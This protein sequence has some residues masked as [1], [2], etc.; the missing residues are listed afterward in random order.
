MQQ[1]LHTRELSD[2]LKLRVQERRMALSQSKFEAE[3]ASEAKSVFLANISHE[4]R[5]AMNG[6]IGL[7][8]LLAE[9]A[10]EA[11]PEDTR[12]SGFA[13]IKVLPAAHA[14]RYPYAAVV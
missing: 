3:Q 6:V 5:T 8:E 4:I 13:G 11:S 7:T 14:L 9:S 10:L 12:L 1:S 2:Q